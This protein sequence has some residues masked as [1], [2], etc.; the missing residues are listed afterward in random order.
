[1]KKVESTNGKVEFQFGVD[2][3]EGYS[4]IARAVY[5]N[6][7]NEYYLIESEEYHIGS[8][9]DY[10]D[11]YFL[12]DEKETELFRKMSIDSERRK[13]EAAL[14][15]E[16]NELENRRRLLTAGEDRDFY[17]KKK[18][19]TIWW[20]KEVKGEHKFSFDKEV[21]F[22]LMSDYPDKL[23]V[24]QKEIFDRENP[25]WAKKLKKG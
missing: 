20:K 2:V 22:D 19:D 21:V 13:K 24:E 23:T 6:A 9:Y 16:R 7:L 17:K 1:M 14:E 11:K 4:R 15:R 8:A 25:I 3:E 10:V 12:L 18:S 5:K